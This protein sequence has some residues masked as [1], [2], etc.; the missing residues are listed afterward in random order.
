MV[1]KCD[2]E[3]MQ[4]EGKF[5]APWKDVLKFY[6]NYY[7]DNV[8]NDVTI[9]MREDANLEFI[10]DIEHPSCCWQLRHRTQ[11]TLSAPSWPWIE[12][13]YRTRTERYWRAQN[14]QAQ[15]LII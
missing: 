6:K 9:D 10:E 1:T 14:E 4:Q 8:M 12:G 11:D 5:T 3:S 2:W 15:K 13:F 7:T